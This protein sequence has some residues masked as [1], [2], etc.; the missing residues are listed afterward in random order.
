LTSDGFAGEGGGVAV[1]AE[2][3]QEDVAEV[4]GGDFGYELGSG[5]VG[6]VPVAREDALF[7]GPGA[8]GVVLEEGFVVVGF[9]HKGVDALDG[10]DDLARGVA[11]VGEDA[12]GGICGG[13]DEP[14]GVGG[15]VGNGEG[16]DAEFGYFK[17]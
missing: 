6:E 9:D 2:V 11:E 4:F 12:E 15:V 17:G 14:Y 7:D 3:G 5:L 13:D 1:L 10:V 16:L 8:F